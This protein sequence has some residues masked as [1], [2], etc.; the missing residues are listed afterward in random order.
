MATRVALA[1]GESPLPGLQPEPRYWD[2]LVEEACA[3][4]PYAAGRRYVVKG[5]E[6]TE[7]GLRIGFDLLVGILDETDETL[8]CIEVEDRVSVAT[9]A[10]A[11]A[12]EAERASV[13]RFVARA[14][15]RGDRVFRA[16]QRR[17]RRLRAE[18]GPKTALGNLLQNVVLLER[19]VWHATL[20]GVRKTTKTATGFP[21]AVR[22]RLRMAGALLATEDGRRR[23][24]YGL[25][26]PQDLATHE[27]AVVLFLGTLTLLFT[28]IVA[29]FAVTLAVPSFAETWRTGFLLFLYA[30]I[31]S[32]GLPLP[33]E[34]LIIYSGTVLGIIPTVATAVAAKIAAGWMAFFLGDEVNDRLHAKKDQSPRYAKFLA[35]SERFANKY[36]LLA[37]AVFIAIPG[38]PD[39]VALYV[40]GSLGMSL[41]RYL[42][43]IAL[44]A[45]ALYTAVLLGVAALFGLH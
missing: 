1:R 21:D 4:S 45:T 34:P 23:V 10:L 20:T 41:R 7:G 16:H 8:S 19:R 36:G 29:H 9:R 15:R 26:H 28:L 27:K 39:A 37:M 5:P 14:R 33:I 35:W 40:F 2:N 25:T 43:G 12:I 3:R 44:G 31:Q 13:G 32:L 17:A 42:L 24:R 30:Y 38:F 6:I 18:G 11:G 22:A